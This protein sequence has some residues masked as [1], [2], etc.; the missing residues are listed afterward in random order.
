MVIDDLQPIAPGVAMLI[1]VGVALL[2][3]IGELMHARRIARIRHLAFGPT[4]RAAWWTTAVPMAR[5]VA[6]GFATWSLLILA[7]IDPEVHETAPSREASKH[8]L[9]AL[10]VSPSMQLHDAG[11]GREKMSRALWAGELVSGVLDR[12]DSS[13]TRVS[14][15]AFYTEARPILNETFDKEVVSNA[16]DGLPMYAAFEPGRTKMIEGVNAALDMAKP[17]MPGSA[18]LLVVSDGDILSAANPM[19]KP[20]AIADTIVL[21]VGDPH[22]TMEVGGHASRQDTTALKTLA[23]RLGGRYHQGNEKHI[24]SDMLA[25]LT[26]IEPRLGDERGLRELALILGTIGTIT[27]ALAG[28]ALSLAGRSRSWNRAAQAQVAGGS[29]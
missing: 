19:R 11:P 3:L 8:L 28:P 2:V 15:V 25:E 26:M 24:P 1:A 9:I 7:T 22:R 17:W 29:A 4:G 20:A 5:V 16:L 14:L 27:L 18:T 23:A 21:G 13:T 10:D 6:A 12:L